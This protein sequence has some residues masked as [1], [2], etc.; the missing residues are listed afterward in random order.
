[1]TGPTLAGIVRRLASERADHP[2]ITFEGRTTSYAE[3]G[4]RTD[5][6]AAGLVAAGVGPGDRVAVLSKNHPA[7]L[8][9]LYGAA[10]CGAVGLPVNWRLAPPE[11]AYI[12]G[13]SEASVLVVGAEFVET[14]ASIEG[15]LGRVRTILVIGESDRYRSYQDWL[16]R[17]PAADPGY[18]SGPDDVIVQM[19]TSGTTGRPKGVQLTNSSVL[20]R[21]GEMCEFWRYDPDSVNLVA[22]PLFHIGGT[23]AALLGLYPVAT[24]VLLPEVD[25]VRIAHT[26]PELHVTNVFLVPAVIQFILQSPGAADADWSSLRAILYG[27]SPITDTVLRAAMDQFNCDFIHLYGITECSGTV[28]QLESRYHDP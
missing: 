2:Y 24:T 25:P 9:V 1:V 13:H 11:V 8:E 26:I 18:L 10:K 17:Q 6:V 28:T 7:V 15:E 20:G 14:V 19:Y 5:R 3:L 12:V 27:A 16:D 22:M 4:Q 23:G 21:M